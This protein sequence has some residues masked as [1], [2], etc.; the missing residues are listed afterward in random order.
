MDLSNNVEQLSILRKHLLYALAGYLILA[1]SLAIFA[2]PLFNVFAQ[3]LLNLLPGESLI[4]T[5]VSAP[6]FIPLK[7][8][9]VFS[10]GLALPWILFQVW[11]YIAP[12]LFKAEKK[13]FTLSLILSTVLFYLGAAFAY[14]LVMP[15]A[16]KFFVG[17][18]P[19]GVRVM[20]D[21]SAYMDF[22]LTLIF[23]FGLGFET[24]LAVILL[25]RTG[26]VKID[27]LKKQRG[28]VVIAAFTLGML[29]TPPDVFSQTLLAIP[30][31]LLFELGLWISSH[32]IEK[33]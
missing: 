2:K 13:V 26:L 15:L 28:Y 29:L 8:S 23:A 33:K 9:L 6:F 7:F 22:A 12:A 14:F 30:L 20:T 17:S 10:L 19:L 27:S 11:G 31:W 3:P 25:V 16:L 5:Q 4:A 18:A 32:L 1:L 21:I 24:P